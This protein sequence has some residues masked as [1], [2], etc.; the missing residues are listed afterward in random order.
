MTLGRG[1]RRYDTDLDAYD[2]YLKA[3]TLIARRGVANAQQAADLFQRVVARDPGFAPAHAGLAH[4][5]AFMSMP[6]R[7]N[8]GIDFDA[9]YPIMRPAAVNAL[10]LDPLLAEAHAAMGWV[11]AYERDLANAEKAFQRAIEL[12]PSLTH[13]YTSYAISTLEPLGKHDEALRLLQMASRHDPLSLDVQREIGRMQVSSG[14]YAE[15]IDTLQRVRAADSDFPFVRQFL[16]RA[17]IGAGR[18]AEAFP[19]MDRP[20][21]WLARVYVMAGRRAE[22]EALVAEHEGEPDELAI[23]YAALGDNDRAFEALERA[24]VSAPHR[25][26]RLLIAPEMAMLRGDP[27]LAVFRRKLGLPET[28][29]QSGPR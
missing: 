26:G 15:A 16:S 24:A 11:Y 4:A 6:S 25:M 2:L 5:Y 7:R 22:A 12:N 10:Q 28:P 29:R 8:G 18:V 3:R 14:R 1:Q 27:R 21:P 19:L 23:I 20:S 17:L 13:L 9:A